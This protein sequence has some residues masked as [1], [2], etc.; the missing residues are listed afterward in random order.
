MVREATREWTSSWRRQW[1]RRAVRACAKRTTGLKYRPRAQRGSSH[2]SRR[3]HGRGMDM[4]VVAT[5]GCTTAT[6]L[7][8]RRRSAQADLWA[9]GAWRKS[10][11]PRASRTGAKGTAQG[12]GVA[13]VPRRARTATYGRDRRGT[14][15]DVEHVCAFPHRNSS[16]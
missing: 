13:C 14:P 5:C 11:G 6:R 3:Q 9:Y 15:G 8:G 2:E 16:V 4:K 7:A 12:Q 10:V 1:R